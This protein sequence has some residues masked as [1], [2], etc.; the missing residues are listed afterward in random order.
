MKRLLEDNTGAVRA[1][2]EITS[3]SENLFS[4]Y[5]VKQNF[6]TEQIEAFKEFENLAN[7]QALSLI[8]KTSNKID[9]FGFRLKSDEM[10]ILDLQIWDMKD[11]SFRKSN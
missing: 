11:L 9:S 2:I 7:N 8:D 10:S 3:V 5:I 6:T 1:E 4:G